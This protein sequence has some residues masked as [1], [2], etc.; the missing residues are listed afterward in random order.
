MT[1]K[2]YRGNINK[3]DLTLSPLSC[4]TAMMNLALG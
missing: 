2:V 4:S 3:K 1:T